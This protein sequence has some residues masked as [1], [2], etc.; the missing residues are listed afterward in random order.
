MKS[1]LFTSFG[2]AALIGAVAMAAG[3]FGGEAQ[4]LDKVKFGTDWIAEAEHGGFYQAKALGIYEKY[5]LD[6]EIVPGGPQ[7]NNPQLVATGA[8]DLASLSSAYLPIIYTKEGIP[9]IA[10]AAFYQ[11]NPTILMAHKEAGLKSLGDMK[12]KPIMV[13]SYAQDSYWPW[14]RSNFGFTDDQ[15]RPYTFNQGPFLADKSAIEQGYV[16]SEP[17]TV[18]LEGAHPQV[19]LLADNGFNDYAS[20]LSAR[21]DM[22]EKKPDVI[23]RFI[24]A[25]VEGWIS[26][27]TQDP[28]K[29]Y[30][31]I[32]KDNPD[33]KLEVMKRARE[34]M[35]QYGIVDSGDTKKLGIGA[36]TDEKWAAIFK[37][38]QASGLA[39]DGMDPKSAYTLQFVDKGFGVK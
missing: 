1:R 25:S 9:V 39:K 30:A 27:L 34:L 35:I 29:A 33:M 10:V 12:G 28:S 26:F 17:Y 37:Q 2:R 15:M 3:L 22:I 7:V 38:M 19:F 6:V 4:A 13:S 32:Q 14:L 5:G 8:L 21:K 16:S 20:I 31:L 11:K 18:E 24:K 36:M 23:E